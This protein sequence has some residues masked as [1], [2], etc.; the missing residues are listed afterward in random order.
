MTL[1]H[2]QL[3]ETLLGRSC[4]GWLASSGVTCCAAGWKDNLQSPEDF[5][6]LMLASTAPHQVAHKRMEVVNIA[7]WRWYMLLVCSNTART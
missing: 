6:E 4:I 7:D 1:G 2:K 5:T 3:V